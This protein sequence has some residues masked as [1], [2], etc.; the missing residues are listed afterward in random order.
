[1]V[2]IKKLRDVPF[3]DS[4]EA[5]NN[6]FV[7]YY[8]NMQMTVSDFTDRLDRD[9]LSPDY[10]FIA[11]YN[12]TPAGIILNGIAESN[13]NKVAW[14]GGTSVALP[15]RKQG[16]ARKLMGST[17]DLY[18]RENVEFANLEAFSV[19]HGAI[20]LYESFG[21]R[22]VDELLFLQLTEPGEKLPFDSHQI[23]GYSLHIGPP[24][25]VCELPYY[26]HD[27]PW[28]TQ[29][30]LIHGGESLIVKDCNGNAAG[31]MLYQKSQ[32]KEGN[33]GKTVLYQ[34]AAD[35]R[36]PAKSEIIQL[37]INQLFKTDSHM[38]STY[39]LPGKS[40]LLIN[41]LEKAGFKEAFTDQKILLKQVFMKKTM[42]EAI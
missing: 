40:H 32:G 17:M 13:G 6:G 25:D 18:K 12:D 33:Q 34:C 16:I 42:N 11:Y 2:K 15:F 8:V 29:W 39:N 22:I 30:D 10:S 7:D 23:Q 41:N 26:Q 38:I 31:Y 36:S 20:R 21:Y 5:W 9:K 35:E 14:N 28:K 24:Q 3:K 1:M 4:C 19:N 27:A 37:M